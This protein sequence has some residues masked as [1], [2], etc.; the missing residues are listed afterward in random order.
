MAHQFKAHNYWSGISLKKKSRKDDS[1]EEFDPEK[2][3]SLK[4]KNLSD[5][6][7]IIDVLYK[8]LKRRDKKID[9]LKEISGDNNLEFHF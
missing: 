3:P 1:L 2:K 7:R 6:K 5:Y 8:E 9:K 4:G